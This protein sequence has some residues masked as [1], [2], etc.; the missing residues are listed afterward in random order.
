MCTDMKAMAVFSA[1]QIYR[2]VLPVHVFTYLYIHYMFIKIE[3]KMGGRFLE[4]S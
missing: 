2:D 4:S 1:K 3:N